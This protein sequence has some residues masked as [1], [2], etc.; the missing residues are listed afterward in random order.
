MPSEGNILKW[1][2]AVWIWYDR[3]LPEVD[4][5]PHNSICLRC[6]IG[7]IVHRDCAVIGNNPK[8]ES[9]LSSST[10]SLYFVGMEIIKYNSRYLLD[11]VM[12]KDL[13]LL[14]F[15]CPICI[16]A[17]ATHSPDPSPYQKRK[18]VAC[19]RNYTRHLYICNNLL[20]HSATLT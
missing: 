19:D 11:I 14:W 16:V 13:H 20:H 5:I 9:E 1:M 8:H 12:F 15:F 17:C 10:S 6:N 4:L 7:K 2:I 3:K 18:K